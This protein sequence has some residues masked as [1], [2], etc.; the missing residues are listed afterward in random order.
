M[1]ATRAQTRTSL[2]VA[3]NPAAALTDVQFPGEVVLQSLIVVS[4]RNERT[5]NV[6]HT[7]L[8][9]FLASFILLSRRHWRLN[10]VLFR[11]CFGGFQ[12][13]DF[14]HCLQQNS[15]QLP[16]IG[17]NSSRVCAPDEPHLVHCIDLALL[18]QR[19]CFGQFGCD[20]SLQFD[21]LL[22]TTLSCRQAASTARTS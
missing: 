7:Q 13:L 6:A 9:S 1:P 2:N 15:Y 4:D 3:Q 8:S 14:S 18:A 11:L 17:C 20:L 16:A 21:H 12:L 10:R 5:T 22:A 19:L